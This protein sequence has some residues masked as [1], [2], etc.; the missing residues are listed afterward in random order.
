MSDFICQAIGHTRSYYS[1]YFALCE[2]CN[3]YNKQFE[4]ED[5]Q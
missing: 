4:R 1:R 3:E 2:Q 5:D